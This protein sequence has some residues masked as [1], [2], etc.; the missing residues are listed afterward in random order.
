MFCIAV[1]PLGLL[2][3]QG[4]VMISVGFNSLAD[5]TFGITGETG[6][7]QANN[8]RRLQMTDMCWQHSATVNVQKRLA[9]TIL[10]ASK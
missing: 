1:R 8:S 2:F 10:E 6:G 7:D 5:G 4:F 9:L 3:L